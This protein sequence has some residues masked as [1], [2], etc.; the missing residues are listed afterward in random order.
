MIQ[1]I[2][3]SLNRKCL[4]EPCDFNKALISCCFFFSQASYEGWNAPV[5]MESIDITVM[6]KFCGE[7]CR[8]KQK[9]DDFTHFQ[10]MRSPVFKLSFCISIKRV[11][12]CF[13][14]TMYDNNLE[15]QIPQTWCD[16]FGFKAKLN[17]LFFNPCLREDTRFSACP[18]SSPAEIEP[19]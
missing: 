12:S 16:L 6:Q 3:F 18:S 9:P 19:S 8:K 17:C 7:I 15:C 5:Y 10:K 1:N 2:R 13:Y 14:K 11:C 4:S